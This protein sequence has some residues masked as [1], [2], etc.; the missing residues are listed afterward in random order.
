MSVGK[1]ADGQYSCFQ[2]KGFEPEKLST[3]SIQK[4]SSLRSLPHRLKRLQAV[5]GSVTSELS[6]GEKRVGEENSVAKR[7]A[8]Q[9]NIEDLP[10]EL[11]HKIFGFLKE[12]EL[13]RT[14]EVSRRFRNNAFE[15]Y[16]TLGV[17]SEI[18]DKFLS[19]FGQ[20]INSESLPVFI[21]KSITP[22]T[23]NSYREHLSTE[24]LKQNYPH[25]SK[26]TKKLSLLLNYLHNRNENNQFDSFSV[27]LIVGFLYEC[28]KKISEGSQ[29]P[30]YEESFNKFNAILKSKEGISEELD[31]FSMYQW[32]LRKKEDRVGIEDL[33]F[34][35][36]GDGFDQAMDQEN[37]C[38]I[39]AVIGILEVIEKT[40]QEPIENK[41]YK[42]ALTAAVF[43]GNIDVTRRLLQEK[44]PLE[45]VIEFLMGPLTQELVNRV[46]FEKDFSIEVMKETLLG[47]DLPKEVVDNFFSAFKHSLLGILKNDRKSNRDSS[48][49]KWKL[50]ELGASQEEITAFLNQ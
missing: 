4:I 48:F 49:L 16:K 35:D 31:S 46:C 1:V 40:L 5:N 45:N 32:I 41:I 37:T 10:N 34:I 6:A 38:Y 8:Q 29:D 14:S 20:S 23:L 15:V 39:S 3:E 33:R 17:K 24:F 11:L 27:M 19:I 30:V 7:S 22:K 47:A 13:R 12:N 43:F 25:L 21:P 36:H 44:M 42:Q 28:T 9:T 2:T 18:Q 26:F 50:F